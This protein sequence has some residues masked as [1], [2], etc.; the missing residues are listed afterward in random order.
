[1]SGLE[2][3]SAWSNT[4][5]RLTVNHLWQ[6]TIF[7]VIALLASLLLRRAPA[8]AR[9]LVWLAAAIKFAL[10]SAVVLLALSSAGI[11]PQSM[12]DSSPRYNPTLHYITPIVSPVANPVGSVAATEPR[13][14]LKGPVAKPLAQPGA[15]R[16]GLVL[17][18]FWLVGATAFFY[19]WVKRRRQVASAIETGRV[20]R[21]GREWQALN[22]VTSWLG[23]TRRVDLIVT[24]AVTEP[25]VWRVLAPIVLLPEAIVSQLTDEELE[26]LM[27]HEM[28]HVLRWDNLVSNLNMVLCCLF[29]FN[30]LVWL[31]DTWLLREREE[32]CDEVVLRWSGASQ[33]YA[34]SIKKIYRFCLNSP[35]SGLSAAGGSRLKHRLERILGNRSDQPFYMSHKVLVGSMIVVSLMLSVVAGLQPSNRLVPRT[36]GAF[37]QPLNKHP[38]IS[39]EGKECIE[40]DVKCVPRA[41]AAI[42]AQGELGHVEVRSDP[43]GP[44]QAG[45]VSLNK[46]PANKAPEGR[47]IKAALEQPAAFQ[48]AHVVDLKQFVGRYAV[49]PSVM[50]NFV[51]DVSLEDGDL[52]FKPSHTQKHRLIAHSMVDYVDSAVPDTRI[53]F[54]F[55]ATGNVE[56]LTLRGWQETIVALRLVLPAPSREGNITF[57]LSGFSGARIVAVAGTF[58]GW[59]QSQ[60]LFAHIGNEWICRINLPPGQYQYKFIVDGNW[61]VDPRNP[62]VVHDERGFENSQMIVR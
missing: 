44:M 21:A 41:N 61:L 40:S 48:S 51:F 56:S 30:P 13:P 18:V 55:D 37:Q 52:W 3:L 10:P 32:A 12:L 9:Y 54:T 24:P 27:M 57:T 28:A 17:S 62:T 4:I 38:V 53:T 5:W 22:K 46:E 29:W 26:T 19:N 33:T 8:R 60:Y 23:I 20:V 35:V 1:M 31:I 49:D 7:F 50:E 42:A 47:A 58:N 34:A 43:G 59:N 15:S 16:V 14:F 39:P 36:Q 25:G 45:T 11:R 6:A 2:L